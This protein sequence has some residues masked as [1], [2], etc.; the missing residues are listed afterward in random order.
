[1][2]EIKV[3]VELP[4]IPDALNNL[5][6]AIA[7]KDGNNKIPSETLHN[8]AAPMT[9]EAP[10]VQIPVQN[11]PVQPVPLAPTVQPATPSNVPV[12]PSGVPVASPAQ[13]TAIPAVEPSQSASKAVTMNDLS[14]A[15]A[16]L[17]DAGKMD[18]VINA[19]KSFGVVAITQLH[20]DQYSSFAECL[21]SLGADI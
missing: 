21:R 9:H 20:E 15:G 13:Q 4:G 16:R 11:T 14:L 19:L 17:V 2:I 7:E 12:A 18:A 6:R 3:T 1:M 8:N 5:A 10:P